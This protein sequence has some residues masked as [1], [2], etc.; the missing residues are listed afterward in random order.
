[1][2]KG[3]DRILVTAFESFYSAFLLQSF[4]RPASCRYWLLHSGI[5]RE[6]IHQRSEMEL[7]EAVD[8]LLRA[9][10]KVSQ[11]VAL[12]PYASFASVDFINPLFS[13]LKTDFQKLIANKR[14]LDIGCG[15]GDVSFLC[16]MLGAKEVTAIDWADTNFNFMQGIR[17]LRDCMDSKI[18]ICCGNLEDMDLSFLGV[19][20]LIFFLGVLYHLPNPI[21]VLRK[22]SVVAP[23]IVAS[24]RVFDVLPGVP[25]NDFRKRRVAYM[26]EPMEC[27]NDSSNWWIPT[28]A[29]V[30]TM[31]ERAGWRMARSLRLDQAIG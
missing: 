8:K 29:A 22:L 15:D 30:S 20:D 10:A 24:T 13:A 28:E 5:A 25:R 6:I 11:R 14:I 16:E 12:Y 21:R 2:R 7:Q 1:M 17:A 26:L 19:R 27:N 23:Q 18:Q 9:R 31:F 3:G 4:Y